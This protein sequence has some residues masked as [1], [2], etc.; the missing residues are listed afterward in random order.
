MSDVYAE[1]TTGADPTDPATLARYTTLRLGGAA[2][3]LETATSADE[4]VHRVQEAER[5]EDPV[6]ILAGG[7]NV[8]I[9][10]R[11]FPGTVVLVRS[12]GLRVVGE[13]ADTV[14]VRVEAGE[15]WDDLVA[16]T[17]ANGWSGLECLSGIPGSAG[18][19][20]IQNVGAYGQEVAETV[21][22]VQVYDRTDGSVGRIDTADCGFVYRGSIFKYSDRWVV[23]SV[24][25][26]LARSALSGPVRYAELARALGVEVGD[27]VPL[28]DAR[29]T[30]LRLRAGKGM[31]LDAADPDTWSVGSFFTNPVLELEAYEL[32]RE[33]AADL[34]EPPA[35]PG[36][37]D[38]VK[39]SAAWLIDKAG[40]AKGHPGP[41]GVAIS[42]KHT[43]ALT[44]R[45]GTAST[46]ALVALAREIR[47]AVHDRFG[48]TLH[49]EPVLI[50]CTI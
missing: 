17:V 38:V 7:S 33:R 27:Q 47:D 45:G 6:L 30:V 41:E 22:G 23:L 12:R 8:V 34:G 40:F 21:T 13:D 31:V 36:A 20:P 14:T 29:A 49:P 39:V 50:N 43:L 15:P 9:G 32:L 48:V 19:T 2:G 4:I 35:W 10:D 24:D 42:S 37:G 28:A 18:A 26:R 16:A 25:F 3:R 44:N 46:A 11:G 5:R 1:S